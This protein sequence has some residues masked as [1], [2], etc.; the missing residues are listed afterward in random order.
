MTKDLAA[1]A[2]TLRGWRQNDWELART[3]E[4]AKVSVPD[5]GPIPVAVP[6]SVRRA[7]LASGE[8]PDPVVGR[9]S[10]ASEWIERR[11]WTFSTTLPADVLAEARRRPGARAVLV[12][13]GLD[14]AGQVFLGDIEVGAFRGSFTPYEFDLTE[15][16]A[17]GADQLSIVFTDVPDGLGQN[18]WTSRIR[19]WKPRF[20]Y[21]W[22]WTPRL[23]QTGI[24]E[25]PRL[26]IRDGGV[27]DPVAVRTRYD[28]S[29]GA[30]ALLVSVAV[31]AAEPEQRIEVSVDGPGMSATRTVPVADAGTMTIDVTGVLEWRVLPRGPQALY[32]VRVRLLSGTGSTDD[33][34]ETRVGFRQVEWHAAEA[35]PPEAEPWLCVV[36]GE[37]LFLQG[38]NWVP[39]RADYA[40]VTP[41]DYRSRLL[42]YRELGV[43]VLRVW[44]GSGLETETFYRLCDELGM[45]VWQELPL[46]SSGLDNAPPADAE[47]AAEL[48]EIAVSYSARRSHHPSLVLWGGGNELTAVTAPAVPGTPLGEDHPALAAAGAAFRRADPDRRYVA[49]S[50]TGPRFEADEREF[51]LGLHHDVHGPWD[52]TGDLVSWQRYWDSDDAVLRS[53]VGVAGASGF[54]LLE[55]FGLLPSGLPDADLRRL[56]THSAGWWLRDFDRRP[57]GPVREWIAASQA[58]Q[59]H[60]LAY[61]A[62]ATKARFP[63]STGFIV[64]MG[65]DAFPCAVSLALL[66]YRGD[67]KPAALA[68][69]E[70]FLSATPEALE[71]AGQESA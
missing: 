15:A 71:P 45:L 62:R 4:R 28:A 47:F 38:V 68:L 12:C 29:T 31:P 17:G 63:R 9:N 65:H 5:I 40:D 56:W 16:L 2:W 36:N 41:E 39:I 14:H 30:A 22:D 46:S 35:S 54:E 1:G 23:V 34:Y 7:L 26:E 70:V 33:L 25:P 64:W 27:L 60:M 43:N 52:H 10:R 13:E 37:P 42:A 21:G 20:N 61:A 6:G 44:G 57:P 3:P 18:G 32:A 50:P 58:R 11:H 66:D 59:A 48:A 69:R 8:I 53:E 24:T 67:P 55:A 19:A 51:G 49:T